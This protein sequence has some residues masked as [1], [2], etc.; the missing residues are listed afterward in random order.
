MEVSVRRVETSSGG[1]EAPTP[2]SSGT[3]C[4]HNDAVYV[5]GGEARAYEALP[6]SPLWCKDLAANAWRQIVVNLDTHSSPRKEEEEDDEEK[7]ER[8]EKKKREKGEEEEEE[9]EE[10]R[11]RT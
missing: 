11:R 8:R 7:K 6:M 10:G 2:W 1:G 4:V 9:E 3:V 5:F